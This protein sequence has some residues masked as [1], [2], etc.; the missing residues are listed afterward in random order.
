VAGEISR[1][2][3]ARIEALKVLLKDMDQ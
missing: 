1:L 2:W 3:P